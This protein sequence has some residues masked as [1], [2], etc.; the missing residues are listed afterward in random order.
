[1]LGSLR[2]R[3]VRGY[4][5]P[6]RW[7]NRWAVKQF[8]RLYYYAPASWQANS[9]AGVKVQQM[10]FDLWTYQ[11][12][13]Y[14]RRP[15]FLVQTGVL[16][17]GSVLFLAWVLDLLG[18]PPDCLVIGVDIALTPEARALSHPRIRLVEGSSVAADVVARVRA[19]TGARQGMVILDSDHA[20]AHVRRELDTYA[21]FVAPGQYLVVEDTN[22]GG[23][24]VEPSFGA[25]PREAVDDFLKTAPD[26]T[27]DDCIWQ[28]QLFSHHQYGWLRRRT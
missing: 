19:L 15:A 9:F 12:I 27:R 25:G 17:G 10:P 26:F 3:L 24:P 13:L 22:L 2:A 28:R 21:P 23:H 14:A 8:H 11:E 4:L 16:R 7:F 6:D 5:Q 18:A 1:M 20:S